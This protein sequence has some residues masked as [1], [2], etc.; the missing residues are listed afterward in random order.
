MY[1][2]P[3]YPFSVC[4]LVKIC[5]SCQNQVCATLL[6]LTSCWKHTMLGCAPVTAT[7][8]AITSS[9][10]TA[11]SVA[12]KPKRCR[13]T[14][15][16]QI[17][18]TWLT[19]LSSCADSWV[20]TQTPV[21]WKS[22]TTLTTFTRESCFFW[23]VVFVCNCVNAFRALTHMEPV[24]DLSGMCSDAYAS[25]PTTLTNVADIECEFCEKVSSVRKARLQ[26]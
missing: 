9:E 6:A 14:S 7:G 22:L 1:K 21:G 15:G 16:W 18:R 23:G 11:T 13:S 19:E 20:P 24:C 2:Y 26:I 5:E 25:T 4:R 17:N 8:L 3:I 10:P 12:N